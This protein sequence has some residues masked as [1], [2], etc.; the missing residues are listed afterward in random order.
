MVRVP[1]VRG[2]DTRIELRSPDS[3]ANPYL[4][5]AVAL[6]AGLEGIEK[7][8]APPAPVDGNI[9]AMSEAELAAAGVESLPATL[10]EAIRE[11]EKDPL[12]MDTLG[13]HIAPLYVTAKKKEFHEYSAQVSQWEVDRY[14]YKY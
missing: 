13:E 7:K 3:A 5:F 12:V 1:S 14:L 9:F 8:I 11:M 2:E 6:R 4:A 10:M